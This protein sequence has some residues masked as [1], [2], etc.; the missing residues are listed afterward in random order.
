MKWFKQI[1][2]VQNLSSAEDFLSFFE[3]PFEAEKLASRH[4]H[5]LKAF[6]IK[7]SKVSEPLHSKAYEVAAQLLSEAYQEQVGQTL[8]KHSPLAIYQRMRPS[9]VLIRDLRK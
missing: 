1:D 7:L 4:L 9:R 6:H 8:A 3:I 2:G 5:I